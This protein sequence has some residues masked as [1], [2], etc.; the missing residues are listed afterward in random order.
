VLTGGFYSGDLSDGGCRWD[1]RC[2]A[3]GGEAKNGRQ[4]VLCRRPRMTGRKAAEMR[5]CGAE[6]V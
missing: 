3:G 6:R 2:G 1:G 4:E 5:S